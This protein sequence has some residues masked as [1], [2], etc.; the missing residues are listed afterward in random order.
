KLVTSVEEYQR[1]ADSTGG[2]LIS[3]DKFDVSD[4]VAIIGEGVETSTV[5][6]ESLA[7]MTGSLSVSLPID[8]SIL[9]FEVRITGVLSQAMLFDIT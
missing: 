3:T 7:E 2:L 5:T 1:L 8:D 9:D 6:L 4:I